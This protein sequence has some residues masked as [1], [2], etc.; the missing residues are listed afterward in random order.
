M[1]KFN[2]YEW[3][4]D[5]LLDIVGTNNATG[6]YSG[7]S[8]I[9]GRVRG[10]QT[11][12]KNIGWGDSTVTGSANSD[13]NLF[14]PQT[15]TRVAGTSTN[16]LTSQLADT[17]QVTG[18][19]TCLVGAK[20][21][22]EAGLFDVQSTLSPTATL[23]STLGVATPLSVGLSTTSGFSTGQYYRQIES[24]V[25]LV[26]GGQNTVTETFTRAML[27]SVSVAHALG[28]AT[29][30]GGDGGAW[31]NG[32]LGSQTATVGAAQGG[33]MVAHADFAGVA[34]SV[35]DSMAF[36]WKWQLT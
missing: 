5:T 17:Y 8:L 6:T 20:T 9:W 2:Q 23:T 24:E 26:T 33:N 32:T 31:L 4:D 10:L 15:E 21:I 36:T 34:L 14:K 16:I 35:N 30:V 13:V 19:M 11:E 7:R 18:T 1:R 22:T 27:A 25:V 28:V 3:I 29:T 12:P